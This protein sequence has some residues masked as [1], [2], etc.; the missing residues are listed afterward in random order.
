MRPGMGAEEGCV[1][2]REVCRG[3]AEAAARDLAVGAGGRGVE[4]GRWGDAEPEVWEGGR[5]RPP[6]LALRV[7]SRW[8]RLRAPRWP[9]VRA[10][11]LPR[12]VLSEVGT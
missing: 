6:G 5:G 12:G 4:E 9:T 2:Q 8:S 1:L 3:T 7:L 10:A 11:F